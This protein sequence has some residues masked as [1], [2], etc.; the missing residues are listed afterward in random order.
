MKISFQ[1]KELKEALAKLGRLQNGQLKAVSR[2]LYG[3]AE[4]V[5]GDS[6]DN[7]VPIDTGALKSS[8]HV[9][10]PK[11]EGGSVAVTLGYGGPAGTGK[12]QKVDVGYA[13]IVHEDLSARHEVGQAKYLEVPLL[14][15]QGEFEDALAAEA[16]KEIGKLFKG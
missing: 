9:Q 7:Y 3:W 13:F 1:S 16:A 10:K 5:M 4:E 2:A 15:H 6:K 11:A 12:G 14:A 8:G